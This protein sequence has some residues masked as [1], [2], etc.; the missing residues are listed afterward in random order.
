MKCWFSGLDLEFDNQKVI[1]GK[2]GWY[3]WAD[4]RPKIWEVRRQGR[5]ESVS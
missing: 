1:R 2:E 4:A 3:L 5:I